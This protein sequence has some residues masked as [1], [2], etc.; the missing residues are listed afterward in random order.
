MNATTLA[1]GI[2]FIGAVISAL[3]AYAVARR[4]TSTEL[5]KA[6]IQSDTQFFQALFAKR[7]EL[8]PELYGVLSDVGLA[9][10]EKRVTRQLLAASLKDLQA[11][12]RK[13]ALLLSP[14]STQ[15]LIELRKVISSMAS[16]TETDP[17][18][19]Q[20]REQLRPLLIEL[21]LSL[22][23]EIGVMQ[24]EGFHNPSQ[25]LRLNE[26]LNKLRE[27]ESAA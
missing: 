9:V 25:V 8:Y 18:R 19:T 1:A 7:L 22:K 4:Q 15:S 11:W 17:S 12:D 24:A 5:R 27:S 23:S 10:V 2:A 14:L 6:R 13:H 20:V 26:V 21:Q 3:V 16:A